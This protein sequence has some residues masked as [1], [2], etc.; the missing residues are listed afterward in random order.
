MQKDRQSKN[1]AIKKWAILDSR[2]V[3]LAPPWVHVFKEK[4]RLPNGRIIPDYYRVIL[5]EYAM[6][7]AM[8]E[9]GK[10][11]L[12][13]GYRHGLKRVTWS[14][15]AGY[16][17]VDEKPLNAARR[18][19]MEETGCTAS[20]WTKI[21]KFVVD[22]NRQGSIMHIYFADGARKIGIP[23]VDDTEEYEMVFLSPS[24]IS[25]MIQKQLIPHLPVAA[26]LAITL[27][28]FQKRAV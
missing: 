22:G 5:P 9:Q 14:L 25:K 7:V 18:E 27:G 6:I 17:E 3:L 23:R 19:L 21:G 2:P 26:A 24:R 4:V 12:L 10:V 20:Q 11:L 8:T 1:R 28:C 15:P 13:R 16:V